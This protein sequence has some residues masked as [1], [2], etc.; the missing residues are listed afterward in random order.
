MA[1]KMTA[2]LSPGCQAKCCFSLARREIGRYGDNVSRVR[3]KRQRRNASAEV[4][5]PHVALL[6]ALARGQVPLAYLRSAFGLSE[7]ELA[8][9]RAESGLFE[10]WD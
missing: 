1:S 4:H 7:T 8:Q 9:A 3:T 6:V 2:T 10:P 5:T